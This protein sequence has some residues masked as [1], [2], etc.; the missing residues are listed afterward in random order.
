VLVNGAA[1]ASALREIACGPFQPA[2]HPGQAL[3]ALA[4][5]VIWLA[6]QDAAA[7]L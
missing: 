7:Q 1:K 5:R 2:L 6:D 4:S 3:R